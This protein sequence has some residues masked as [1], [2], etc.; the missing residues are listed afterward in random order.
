M[1][2]NINVKN[3]IYGKNSRNIEF[4]KLKTSSLL[5][6]INQ[7]IYSIWIRVVIKSDYS[8]ASKLFEEGSGRE[9]VKNQIEMLKE[10]PDYFEKVVKFR[11]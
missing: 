7:K 6:E 9:I 8:E 3:L 5:A 10:N 4:L 2:P 1:V 11:K